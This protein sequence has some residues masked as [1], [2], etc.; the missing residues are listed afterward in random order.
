VATN[1]LIHTKSAITSNHAEENGSRVEEI[2]IRP[3][4]EL[5]RFDLREYYRYR[6]LLASL[7]WR[8]IRLQFDQMYL[9]FVWASI[10]P[11]LYVAVF[12]AFRNLSEANTHV[13]IPYPLYV[14]SGLI[15]WY[16]F[17][18]ASTETADCVK[19]DA[20]LL[21]KV[22]YPRLITPMV[23]VI[24][25]LVGL[26]MALAPLLF[27]MAW[28]EAIPSWN[29]VFLPFVVVQTMALVMGIGAFLASVSLNNR[30]WERVLNAV[31]YIGL[32]ISPVLYAPD[33]IPAHAQVIY[34]INPMAGTLGAFRSCFFSAYPFPWEQWG[35]SL[36]V[37]L[38]IL[39]LGVRRYRRTETLFAD[40]L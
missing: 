40:Q 27:M 4:S 29:V 1:L 32:F 30:D 31:F 10:R 21:T 11:L 37:S 20:Y 17:V 26:G 23:S 28:Y 33:M 7:I 14:Y 15:L 6:H 5:L 12:V 36:V 38:L 9:G 16:Y 13:A 8:E 39:F 18:E 22:Y 3:A 34:F 2:V 25:K 24:A 19:R 35:Y